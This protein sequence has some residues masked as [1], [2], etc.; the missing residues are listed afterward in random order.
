MA[1]KGG[2]RRAVRTAPARARGLRRR[3]RLQKPFRTTIH[4]LLVIHARFSFQ[5]IAHI[6]A[7]MFI[8]WASQT[9]TLMATKNTKR[10]KDYIALVVDFH[11]RLPFLWLLVFF[12]ALL[13][14]LRLRRAVCSVALCEHGCPPSRI[15][16]PSSESHNPAVPLCPLW[17]CVNTAV[18]PHESPRPL[19]QN[20]PRPEPGEG[21]PTD[22]TTVI[23][24]PSSVFPSTVLFPPA[25][26]L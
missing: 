17:L 15:S 22:M 11:S 26:I 21:P 3:P 7:E 1:G 14:W 10:H 23:R 8:L 5:H 4:Q 6:Q 12:V 25:K 19:R 20:P 2:N 18:P 24:P 16:A 13:L 9:K